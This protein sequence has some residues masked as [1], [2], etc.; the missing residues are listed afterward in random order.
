MKD[1]ASANL[2]EPVLPFELTLD[3]VR[4]GGLTKALHRQLRT[5]I[6]ERRLPAGYALPSTRQLASALD[7]GRNTVIAAYDMLVAAGYAQARRGARLVVTIP[8][9]DEIP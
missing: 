2:M 9:A 4:A 3:G 6:L 8:H 1:T 7:V 5:A